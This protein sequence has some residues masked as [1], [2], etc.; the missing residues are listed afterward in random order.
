MP[1][2]RKTPFTAFRHAA[3]R[4]GHAEFPFGGRPPFNPHFMKSFRSV[5]LLVLAFLCLPF[6][7]EA[8]RP[9]GTEMAGVITSVNHTSRSVAFTQDDGTRREFV[10]AERAQFW[11]GG[12]DASPAA[13]KPGMHVRISL[14][15]PLIGA[16]FVTQIV[17]LEPAPAS[18]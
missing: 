8:R 10:Y 1:W 3:V 15:H 5:F 2:S 6:A 11:H 13:L 7:A 4:G 16:D 18:R 12:A 17:L 14:H 9:R